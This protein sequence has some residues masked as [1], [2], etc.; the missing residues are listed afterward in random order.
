MVFGELERGR[1]AGEDE[2][3][4]LH[5]AG[6]VKRIAPVLVTDTALGSF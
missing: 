2:L 3:R 6:K 4:G 1:A 5:F